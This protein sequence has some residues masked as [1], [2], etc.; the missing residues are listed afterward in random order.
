MIYFLIIVIAAAAFVFYRYK[1]YKKQ[2]ELQESAQDAQAFVSSEVVSLLQRFKELQ[3]KGVIPPHESVSLQNRIKQITEN[4][5][6]HTDSENSVRE[7]LVNAK[8]DLA[9]ISIKLDQFETK[10]KNMGQQPQVQ[11]QAVIPQ[12]PPATSP[13]TQPQQNK[14]ASEID[15]F[16][17]LK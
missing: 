15:P 2:L 7:Y 8:Q 16:D 6:C 9:L 1:K 17:A 12:T 3:S 5:F 13:V 4:M 10:L 14:P 11:P